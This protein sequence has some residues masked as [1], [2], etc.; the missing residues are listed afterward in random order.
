MTPVGP[1]ATARNPLWEFATWAYELD[2]VAKSCL[3]LQ[4]R[5][6]ADVNMIMFCLWLGSRGEG[7]ANLARHLS[8]ALKLSR[9]W[10]FNFVEPLRTCR[11]NL[12]DFVANAPLEDEHR[13]AMTLLRDRV[14]Q[15]ELDME[16]M[17]TTAL[18]ALVGDAGAPAGQVPLDKQRDVAFNN[19][20][21]YLTATGVKLDPLGA[22]HV[23]HILDT[24]FS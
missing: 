1:V 8:A 6:G 5:F 16:R 11:T 24:V 9:E 12:K 4:Q 2:G 3:A 22:S 18:Y 23:R 20:N 21:V 17:Q 15:C 13:A 14:K 19:L 10:Q 7:N